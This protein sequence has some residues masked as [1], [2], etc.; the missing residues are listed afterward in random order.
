MLCENSRHNKP[1]NS[2]LISYKVDYIAKGK[3]DLKKKL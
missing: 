2:L 1:E 3:K